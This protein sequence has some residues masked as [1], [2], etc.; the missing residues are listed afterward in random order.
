V[1]YFFD[2]NIPCRLVH[3][4]AGYDAEHIIVH[5]DDDGRFK[6][7]STDVFLIG[8][9]SQ[10]KPKPV[11][12]TADLNMRT[13]HPSERKALAASELTLVF[14][15]KV[16][17]NQQ[18]H[19]QAVKMLRV[20]PSITKAIGRCRAPIAFEVTANGKLCKLGPTSGL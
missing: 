16:F 4:L 13:K 15:R 8:T 11:L 2:R 19:E 5:Q 3:M 20:W 7:D 9:L 10:E 12:L 17:H 14:F 1:K 18:I 6:P